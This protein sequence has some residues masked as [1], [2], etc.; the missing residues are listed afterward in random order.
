MVRIAHV[1]IWHDTTSHDVITRSSHCFFL[2]WQQS[3][4]EGRND[5]DICDTHF[6]V[7]E[8]VIFA[9]QHLD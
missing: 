6:T 3:D 9:P 5:T 4:D 8:D 2:C 1:P 7:D